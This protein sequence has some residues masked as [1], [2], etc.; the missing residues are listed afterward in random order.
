MTLSSLTVFSLGPEKIENPP[1]QTEQIPI[2]HGM[3]WK[4]GGGARGT[5]NRTEYQRFLIDNY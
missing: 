3:R 4:G 1:N 5:Y 2:F